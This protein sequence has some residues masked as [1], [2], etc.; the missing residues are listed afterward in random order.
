M[1]QETL[2]VLF[3]TTGIE[4]ARK[5][6]ELTSYP[7]SLLF[8][9]SKKTRI[10]VSLY[11]F[12]A[13]AATRVLTEQ[14]GMVLMLPDPQFGYRNTLKGWTMMAGSLTDITV[15]VFMPIVLANALHYPDSFLALVASKI[16]INAA[17]HLGLDGARFFLDKIKGS[18][19]WL[20][21]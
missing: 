16:A 7:N 18:P 8:L 6:Y 2:K 20:R 3:K 10:L 15:G 12:V 13:P 21:V 4:T 19:I 17:T 14:S 9:R 1:I 5:V 11:P